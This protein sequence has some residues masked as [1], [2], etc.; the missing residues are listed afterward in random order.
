M[1]NIFLEHLNVTV[2]DPDETAAML[3]RLFG[4]NL[5]WSG[6]AIYDGRSVHVGSDTSYLALYT[7]DQ[8]SVSDNIS[9]EKIGGLNHIGIVVTNLQAIEQKVKDEKLATFNHGDYEPG[10]RFYFRTSDD[11]EFEVVSYASD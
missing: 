3:C 10:Q 6:G 7:S 8:S 9:Q 1:S 2:K 5:R 4:W 11:I